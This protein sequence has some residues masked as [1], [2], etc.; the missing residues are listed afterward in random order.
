MSVPQKPLLGLAAA[1]F[2]WVGIYQ[3]HMGHMWFFAEDAVM[4]SVFAIIA[5]GRE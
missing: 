5:F 3:L 1:M 2:A 4:S